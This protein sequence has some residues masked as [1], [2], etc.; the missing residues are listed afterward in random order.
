MKNRDN[1]T[2]KTY[3]LQIRMKIDKIKTKIN[4]EIKY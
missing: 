3:I 1:D 4:I 2:K